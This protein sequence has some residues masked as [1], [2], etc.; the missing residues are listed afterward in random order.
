MDTIAFHREVIVPYY[1]SVQ[2][3]PNKDYSAVTGDR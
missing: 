1:A 3:F 2:K